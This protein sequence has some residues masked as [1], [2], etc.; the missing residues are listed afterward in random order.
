M[1][2][3]G[4]GKLKE[5]IAVLHGLSPKSSAAIAKLIKQAKDA[6]GITSK[7]KS[8]PDDVKLAI[9]TWHYE[10]LNPSNAVQSDMSAKGIEPL[11]AVEVQAT[12]ETVADTPTADDGDFHGIGACDDLPL[13]EQPP[14]I[15]NLLTVVIDPEPMTDTANP[16]HVGSWGGA[17]PNAGRKTTGKQTITMRVPVEL[18]GFVR[19]LKDIGDTQGQAA[20]LAIISGFESMLQNSSH[21][22][23][24]HQ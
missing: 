3:N 14:A 10:R 11:A 9:Y 5:A 24:I 21:A 2:Y 13:P 19:Q 12:P 16:Q 23:T 6:L 18:V 7:A 22:N 8:L 1:Q 20:L 4:T 15:E 17:R